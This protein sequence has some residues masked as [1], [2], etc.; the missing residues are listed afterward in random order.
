MC[1]DR[2]S[3]EPLAAAS[4]TTPITVITGIVRPPPILTFETLSDRIGVGPVAAG[5]ALVR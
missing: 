1:V 3:I 4:P 2:R 5:R